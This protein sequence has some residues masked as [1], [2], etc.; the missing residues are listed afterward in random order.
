MERG[1]VYICS[2][3]FSLLMFMVSFVFIPYILKSYIGCPEYLRCKRETSSTSLH[4]YP[5]NL[6]FRSDA[7]TLYSN[8]PFCHQMIHCIG[9]LWLVIAYFCNKLI[10]TLMV[11]LK[12]SSKSVSVKYSSSSVF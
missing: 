2:V 10:F 1:T 3:S 11:A 6:L 12:T 8:G 7:L 9:L 5:V 4:V